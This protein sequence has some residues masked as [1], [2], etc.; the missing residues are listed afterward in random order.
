MSVTLMVYIQSR[1]PS[2]LH[3]STV[4]P[5]LTHISKQNN[6]INCLRYVQSIFQYRETL[7]LL[8]MRFCSSNASIFV[9]VECV[10]VFHAGVTTIYFLINTENI[11]MCITCYVLNTYVAFVVSHIDAQG[12]INSIMESITNKTSQIIMNDL[13]VFL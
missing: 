1:I 12:F 7:V 6:K 4:I 5:V 8:Q 3:Y 2:T 9:C 13:F 11:T 10:P